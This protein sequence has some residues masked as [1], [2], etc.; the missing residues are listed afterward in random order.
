VIFILILSF[1]FCSCEKIDK[2]IEKDTYDF[3]FD[4][5]SDGKHEG[6][7]WKIGLKTEYKFTLSEDDD[8][9]YYIFKFHKPKYI[10]GFDKGP[11]ASYMVGSEFIFQL[12]DENENEIFNFQ[13]LDY[14]N[15]YKSDKGADIWIAK[16]KVPEDLSK[17]RSKLKR[18]KTRYQINPNFI[19]RREWMPG[20][21][22]L[23]VDGRFIN[24]KYEPGHW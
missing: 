24:T 23:G 22:E 12:L 8:C 16:G 19:A 1:L 2:A 20:N 18:A 15:T 6:W 13:P 3:I 21:P 14:K 17:F 11:M 7:F 10:Q 4:Y 5:T 9:A